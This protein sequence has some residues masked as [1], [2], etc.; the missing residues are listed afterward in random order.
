MLGLTSRQTA[1]DSWQRIQIPCEW[2]LSSIIP[3]VARQVLVY[4]QA[5][6]LFSKFVRQW[7]LLIWSLTFAWLSCLVRLHKGT[8]VLGLFHRGLA[9]IPRIAVFVIIM[10]LCSAVQQIL[11]LVPEHWLPSNFYK[12]WLSQRPATPFQTSLVAYL[13]LDIG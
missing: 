7:Q 8:I 12:E 3:K 9:F 5:F 2:G 4:T 6:E 1:V 13:P 10:D 11:W